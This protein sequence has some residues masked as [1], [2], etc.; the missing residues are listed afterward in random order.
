MDQVRVVGISGSLRRTSSNTGLLR[1][2]IRLAPPD[3]TLTIVP[4]DGIPPFN[5]D[6]E[7]APPP[8]VRHLKEAVRGA[9]AVLFAVAEYNYSVSGV[10]KNA[11]DWGSRPDGENAWH[12]KPVALMGASVGA[13][14]TLRAQLQLRQTLLAL[15]M[16]P[17][18]KPELMVAHNAEKFDANGDLTDRALEPRIT[19]LL[20]ALAR[21]TRTLQ[22]EPRP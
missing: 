1:A 9:D 2:G 5:P 21:W 20:S 7:L 3:V 16:R 6:E 8:A 15:D 11:I 19:G 13:F 10:L 22:S 12:R 17:M 4:L 18:Q 14:G